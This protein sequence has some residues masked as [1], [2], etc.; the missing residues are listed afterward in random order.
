MT[1]QMT[2]LRI[3]KTIIKT[4]NEPRLFGTQQCVRVLGDD[5]AY[6][7]EDFESDMLSERKNQA[8]DAIAAQSSTLD[9]YN[10][11]LANDG[12]DDVILAHNSCSV[13]LAENDPWWMIT[14]NS[15]ICFH[16]VTITTATDS[17]KFH[18]DDDNDAS[19]ILSILFM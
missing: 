8:L 17:G 2:L 16:K 19:F 9:H 4:A 12:S 13:T 6:Y 7:G 3:K 5:D 15:V 1:L 11:E 10:P 18:N 14:F